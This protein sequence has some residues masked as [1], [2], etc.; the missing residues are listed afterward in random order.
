MLNT[1]LLLRFLIRMRCPSLDT[2]A[3]NLPSGEAVALSVL[4]N[5]V[6]KPGMITNIL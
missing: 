1:R 3:F 2:C 5:N 4:K 6:G